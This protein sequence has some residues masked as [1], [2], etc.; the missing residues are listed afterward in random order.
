M[1]S[2]SSTIKEN[3]K[4][5][6]FSTLGLSLV[7]IVSHRLLVPQY[8]IYE[9]KT[10]NPEIVKFFHQFEHFEDFKGLGEFHDKLTWAFNLRAKITLVFYF[11]PDRNQENQIDHLLQELQK[12]FVND[13]S[14]SLETIFDQPVAVGLRPNAW[15]ISSLCFMISFILSLLFILFWKTWK[16]R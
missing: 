10:E 8:D 4:A 15:V 6:F 7:L 5:I 9:V 13:K 11:I 3:L 14:L 12:N 16:A 1:N 2:L